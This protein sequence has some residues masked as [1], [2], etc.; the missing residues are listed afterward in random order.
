MFNKVI[1]VF[2][3]GA[4]GAVIRE[5]IVLAGSTVHG[6]FP[7][8]ILVANLIAAFF[9]GFVAALAVEHS[10]IDGNL[11]LFI[12]TGIMGGLST[13]ST[14][15]WG[16]VTL[17]QE[18]GQIWIGLTYLVGSLT[19]GLALVELGLWLGALPRRSRLE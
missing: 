15:I 10:L 9:I 16:T 11:Q 5:C 18:P 14:L 7:T 2:F 6:H 1:L 8:S 12:S 17:S 19:A 4:I 3:G 13:F